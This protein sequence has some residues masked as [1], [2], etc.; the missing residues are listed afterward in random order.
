MRPR[1]C[2]L[3]I[4]ADHGSAARSMDGEKLSGSDLRDSGPSPV[5]GHHFGTS[6]SILLDTCRADTAM[7]TTARLFISKT[8][9]VFR[10]LLMRST[11][12]AASLRSRNLLRPEIRL[13]FVSANLSPKFPAAGYE[14]RW[15]RFHPSVAAIFLIYGG[16]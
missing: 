15:R 12:P 9:D 16:L 3:Q 5:F 8:F 1:R 4:A 6:T 14:I 2:T 10:L 11:L 7:G 13:D